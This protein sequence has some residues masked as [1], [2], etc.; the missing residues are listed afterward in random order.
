MRQAA[1]SSLVFFLKLENANVC[2][3]C[4]TKNV[5][6]RVERPGDLS[7]LFHVINDQGMSL[8]V[9]VIA[10]LVRQASSS[11]LIRTSFSGNERS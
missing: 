4:D 7:C 8:A 3:Y 10:P 11:S 5:L 2:S 9:G 1:S 6:A